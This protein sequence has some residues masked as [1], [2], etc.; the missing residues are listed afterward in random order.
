MALCNMPALVSFATLP[1][2]QHTLIMLGLQ[3][4]F[5]KK[6]QNTPPNSPEKHGFSSK[7][8]HQIKC[9]PKESAAQQIKG[10]LN[11]ECFEQL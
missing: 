3:S 10:S 6:Q 2:C 11:K 9:A 7:I 8:S 5:F 1:L 4:H